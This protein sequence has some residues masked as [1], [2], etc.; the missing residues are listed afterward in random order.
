MPPSLAERADS[1]KGTRRLRA[2]MDSSRLVSVIVTARGIR[3]TRSSAKESHPFS[4]LTGLQLGQTE[5]PQLGRGGGLVRAAKGWLRLP[6][7][8]VAP[9]T[10]S[11]THRPRRQP[12]GLSVGHPCRAW[13]LRHLNDPDLT[14]RL[15]PTSINAGLQP[16]RFRGAASRCTFRIEVPHP[17]QVEV[18]LPWQR[19]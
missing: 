11:L 12:R 3:A 13:D 10:R 9:S 19:S 7:L 18:S 17:S 6:E 5:P 4:A 15:I 1:G 16:A 2:A 8:R 14:A